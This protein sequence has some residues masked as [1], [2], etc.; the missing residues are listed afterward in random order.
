MDDDG[1]KALQLSEFK[2]GLRESSFNINEQDLVSL[3]NYFDNDKSGSINFDEFLAG[4][5]VCMI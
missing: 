4:L 2:K 5:R 3:F 1:S